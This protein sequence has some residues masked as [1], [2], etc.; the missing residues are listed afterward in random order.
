MHGPGI[1][2]AHLSALCVLHPVVTSPSLPPLKS[3]VYRRGQVH[4]LE[5]YGGVHVGEVR[6]EW[7]RPGWARPGSYACRLVLWQWGRLRGRC[8]QNGG[9]AR[10][11]ASRGLD[12]GE[13]VVVLHIAI[14]FCP[15]APANKA[16]LS[17]GTT[18]GVTRLGALDKVPEDQLNGWRRSRRASSGRRR[19]RPIAASRAWRKLLSSLFGGASANS[20]S[21]PGWRLRHCWH[22]CSTRP[23]S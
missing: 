21:P 13:A 10:C 8:R 7:L 15:E 1:A 11:R 4:V 19:L 16:D 17:P 20:S 22:S 12:V 9:R 14:L 3:R 5:P 23:T 2:G 18:I 6:A